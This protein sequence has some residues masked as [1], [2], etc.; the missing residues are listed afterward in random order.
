LQTRSFELFSR[1]GMKKMSGKIL[2]RSI[3]GSVL[4]LAIAMGF[5]STASAAEYTAQE[6]ANIA[7]VR[8]LYTQLDA[9]DARGDTRT[10]ILGIAEK[11]ISPNY[12]QQNGQVGRDTFTSV[13][14]GNRGGGAP[15]GTGAGGPPGRGGAGGPPA[16]VGAGAL[17]GRGGAGGPPTGAGAPGGARQ[18]EIPQLLAIFADGDEV[19]QFTSRGGNPIFNMF[20]VDKDAYIYKHWPT[21]GPA[22]GTPGGPPGGAPAG[23]PAG[24]PPTRP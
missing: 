8:A 20:S 6:L 7:V 15:G 3:A 1:K 24:A 19:I 13:F 22:G 21:G 10:A 4:S 11:Y 5:S 9:A 14:T 17:P 2:H 18:L 16:G 23:A 12:Q